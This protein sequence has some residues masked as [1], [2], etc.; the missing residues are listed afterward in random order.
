MMSKFKLLTAIFLLFGSL[1][2]AQETTADIQGIIKDS[3]NSISNATIV[4][5][6]VPTGTKYTTTTRKD[7][8]Y[9]LPNLRIGGPYEVTVSSVGYKSATESNITL[10]LGQEYKSDFVLIKNSKELT[11]V[12]VTGYKQDKI[13]SSSHTG[14][15]EI[16]SRTQIER[17]P[18]INRSLQDFTKLQPTGII[19]RIT[20]Q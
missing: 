15:Q 10:L 20:M 18:T 5:I 13:F 14:S 17:L 6:H 11:E 12:V 2:K 4:A 3:T 9:N 8:R 19:I 7:G 1:A 16:I